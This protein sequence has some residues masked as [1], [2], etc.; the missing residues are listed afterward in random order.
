[1]CDAQVG[2]GK[3]NPLPNIATN[4]N[5]HY[6][7]TVSFTTT[8]VMRKLRQK[9][10]HKPKHACLA[11]I[12]K[13]EMTELKRPAGMYFDLCELHPVITSVSLDTCTVYEIVATKGGAPIGPLFSFSSF[14]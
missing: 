8:I 5:D 11:Q 1:M 13:L 12:A 14:E 3:S 4:S 9:C 7:P 2:N 10:E 6:S